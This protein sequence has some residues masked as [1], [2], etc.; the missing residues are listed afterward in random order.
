MAPFGFGFFIVGPVQILGTVFVYRWISE[1]G[2]TSQGTPSAGTAPGNNYGH[3]E[4]PGGY[5]SMY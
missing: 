5:M 3:P 4:Q 1:H 2:S